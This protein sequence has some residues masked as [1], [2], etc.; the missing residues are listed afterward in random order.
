MGGLLDA[1][2]RLVVYPVVLALVVGI[3]AVEY[4]NFDAN[5]DAVEAASHVSIQPGGGG[6]LG[7]LAGSLPAVSGSLQENSQKA[8]ILTLDAKATSLKVRLTWE[9][10]PAQ[11][12]LENQPDSFKVALASPSGNASESQLV[13]NPVGGEG[14]V[15]L[16]LRVGGA[17]EEGDWSVT[18]FLGD[19]GDQQG[20][21]RSVA[22]TGNAYSLA[23]SYTYPGVE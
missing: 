11:F 16:A 5:F 14:L 2:A 22:D 4:V 23:I 18:V 8:T 3:F 20:F 1:D 6:G 19:C 12:P 17:G 15:E 7:E 21:V 9:D 10:E 13:S